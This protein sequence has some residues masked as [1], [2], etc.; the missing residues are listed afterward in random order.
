M[1]GVQPWYWL[2]LFVVVA[3]VVL[4]V[5][6]IVRAVSKPKS[7]A[8]VGQSGTAPG[9]YPDPGNP[10]VQRYFDGLTWTSSTRPPG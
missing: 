10:S 8:P 1:G 9:W 4:A 3:G 6:F 2:I 5:V 7:A